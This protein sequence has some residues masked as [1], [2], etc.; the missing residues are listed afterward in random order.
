VFFQGAERPASGSHCTWTG[1]SGTVEPVLLSVNFLFF[2][3][4]FGPTKDDESLLYKAEHHR[5]VPRFWVPL[6]GQGIANERTARSSYAARPF[7]HP[8]RG[9]FRMRQDAKSSPRYAIP[10]IPV[11]CGSTG[12]MTLLHPNR[13]RFWGASAGR[14]YPMETIPA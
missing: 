8:V 4:R 7:S 10:R 9:W 1:N 5:A 14:P 11:D 2:G 12:S 6:C 13:A 3:L